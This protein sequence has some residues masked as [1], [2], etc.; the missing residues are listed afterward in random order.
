LATSTA[1]KE[2]NLEIPSVARSGERL[3][4]PEEGADASAAF[5]PISSKKRGLLEPHRLTLSR[6]LAA[7]LHNYY[8]QH[9][10]FRRPELSGPG[11]S[12]PMVKTVIKNALGILGVS[13]PE[14]M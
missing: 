2:Q 8:Y 11:C 5:Y 3:V 10:S 7:L 13:A 4:A 6:H 12:Q 14:R 9:G 1:G